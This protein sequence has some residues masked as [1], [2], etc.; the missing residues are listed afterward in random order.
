MV[1]VIY[2]HRTTN[3]IYIIQDTEVKILNLTPAKGFTISFRLKIR[4]MVDYFVSYC[5]YSM[6]YATWLLAKCC[7]CLSFFFTL[8]FSDLLV[9]PLLFLFNL[10]EVFI[11]FAMHQM[12]SRKSTRWKNEDKRNTWWKLRNSEIYEILVRILI[13]M[14]NTNTWSSTHLEWNGR[15]WWEKSVDNNNFALF[16]LLKSF[17]RMH[18]ECTNEMRDA[19]HFAN[20]NLIRKIQ[21]HF[22]TPI[23]PRST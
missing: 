7:C 4:Y 14:V 3:T 12:P 11:I 9:G 20:S 19:K 17:L 8:V 15:K 18:C 16:H 13:Q 5:H 21:F 2:E 6:P 23:Y 1:V 22:I 10:F